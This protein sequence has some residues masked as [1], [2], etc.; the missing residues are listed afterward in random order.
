MYYMIHTLGPY[1]YHGLPMIIIHLLVWGH[2]IA[3]K[4]INIVMT[5]CIVDN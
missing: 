2:Q 1:F 3:M 5:Q 4:F